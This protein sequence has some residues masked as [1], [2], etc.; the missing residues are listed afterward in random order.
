MGVVSD[1]YKA[2]FITGKAGG[3]RGGGSEQPAATQQ[4]VLYEEVPCESLR[5]ILSRHGQAK[6]AT[7]L[8]LDVD[9]SGE[10]D[11]LELMHG[12]TASVVNAGW[13]RGSANVTTRLPGRNCPTRPP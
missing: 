7:F 9:G 1:A 13:W 3:E 6:G 5:G 11:V 12:I 10:L 4:N 8:S 2:R